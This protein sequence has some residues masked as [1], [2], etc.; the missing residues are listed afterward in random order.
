MA[1]KREGY[2]SGEGKYNVPVKVTPVTTDELSGGNKDVSKAVWDD[3]DSA[4]IRG[5]RKG[6]S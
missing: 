6:F 3:N 2:K 4:A 1:K 5:T